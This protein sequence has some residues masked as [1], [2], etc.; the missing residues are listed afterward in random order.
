MKLQEAKPE[1]QKNKIDNPRVVS[2][3]AGGKGRV[4]GWNGS[5]AT[6]SIE[7]AKTK[8]QPNRKKY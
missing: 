1:T 6:M 4:K 8:R 7:T 5:V 3:A 2:E